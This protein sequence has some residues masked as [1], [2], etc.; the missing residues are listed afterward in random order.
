VSTHT[1]TSHSYEPR[2]WP[3][4]GEEHRKALAASGI[5]R[6]FAGGGA[7]FHENQLPD[8]VLILRDGFVKVSCYSVDGREIVLGIRGPGDVVGELSAID[9]ESRSASVIALEPVEALAMSTASFNDFLEANPQALRVLLQILSGRL[10][11]ADRRRVEFAAKDT[12]GRVASRIVELSE[13]FGSPAEGDIQIDFPLTQEELAGW[14]AC[15][16]DSVVKALQSM[17]D[18]GW[19]ETARKRITV[20]DLAAVRRTAG[21]DA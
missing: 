6:S 16:R 14:T 4:L 7:L 2:F 20:R 19:I 5:V 21:S 17:R 10:R 11:D 13:R 9:G 3:A 12:M 8:R 1:G 18:L 15:S